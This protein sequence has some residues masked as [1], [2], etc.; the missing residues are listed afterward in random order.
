MDVEVSDVNLAAVGAQLA[1][2]EFGESGCPVPPAC[3]LAHCELLLPTG[4]RTCSA[5][6]GAR[7]ATHLPSG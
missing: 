5:Q 6:R 4:K 3:S 2:Q 7:S 1:S